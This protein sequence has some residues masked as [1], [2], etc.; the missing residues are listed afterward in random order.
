M[1]R[2]S[3]LLT[4][5]GL[6]LKPALAAFALTVV[7]EHAAVRCEQTLAELA[8]DVRLQQAG[9]LQ[10]ATIEIADMRLAP[11]SVTAYPQGAQTTAV[12]FLV[13]TSDPARQPVVSRNAEHIAEFLKR[14]APHVR[15]G[16]AS[17]DTEW[18]LLNPIGSARHEL[19]DSARKLRATGRTTELYRNAIAALKYLAAVAADRRVLVLMS[20]GLAEDTAYRHADVV[21]AALAGDIAI[22]SLGYPRSVALSV[23]L[24]SLRRLSDETGGLYRAAEWPAFALLPT[25]IPELLSVIDSGGK[26]VF[27]LAA[28]PHGPI[29]R[30]APARL[31]IGA[32][33]IIA[34]VDFDL[35][36]ADIAG[37]QGTTTSPPMATNTPVPGMPPAVAESQPHKPQPTSSPA[38][39]HDW[40]VLALAI[41]ML[42][43]VLAGLGTYAATRRRSAPL[44]PATDKPIPYGFL[45][46]TQPVAKRYTIARTPWRIGRSPHN[47]LTIADHS[48]SRLHAE[49]RCDES[50]GFV[51]CDLGS[52]NGVFINDERQDRAALAEGDR[53][54]I[55]DLCLTFT[56]HDEDYASLEPTVMVR[57]RTPA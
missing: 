41:G 1:K 37:N 47:D 5:L 43:L 26:L 32:E 6:L 12:L 24:Q 55:G 25:I 36:I 53:I 44:H 27:D 3:T 14:A 52:T 15:F 18:I 57:T 8:C 7:G 29:G 30:P 11:R 9:A 39:E 56:Y 2:I 20:D 35:D 22:V 54:E 50:G 38:A 19:E 21:K 13:D 33:P 23:G 51:L 45:L 49:I 28:L 4:T 48:V 46:L 10:T 34:T 16:L 40:I 31:N 17:F 42:A